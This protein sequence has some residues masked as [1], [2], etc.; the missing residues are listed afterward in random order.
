MKI[1]VSF[2]LLEIEFAPGGRDPGQPSVA[3]TSTVKL[4]SLVRLCEH[5]K[6][7]CRPGGRSCGNP[8]RSKF[9]SIINHAFL[10]RVR[11]QDIAGEALT[12]GTIRVGRVLPDRLRNLGGPAAFDSLRDLYSPKKYTRLTFLKAMTTASGS[13]ATS[14]SSVSLP[15]P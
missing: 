8:L 1:V 2:P 13:H 3:L 4:Q 11:L 14:C 10:G 7:N 12:R 6:K 5:V 9:R 15:S